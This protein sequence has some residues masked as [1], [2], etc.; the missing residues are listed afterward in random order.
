[1][2]TRP[3]GMAAG[4]GQAVYHRQNRKAKREFGETDYEAGIRNRRMWTCL[5]FML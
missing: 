4:K 2:V 1:M 5:L 3:G